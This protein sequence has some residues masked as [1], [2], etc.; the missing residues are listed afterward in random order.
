MFVGLRAS[1]MDDVY[2]FYKADA[3]TNYPLV[4]SKLSIQCYFE[5]L[6]KSYNLYRKKFLKKI[7]SDNTCKLIFIIKLKIK[8]CLLI[9][10]SI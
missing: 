6:C 9:F 5:A 1:H 8:I 10:Y 4:N 2:D 3:C 7:F